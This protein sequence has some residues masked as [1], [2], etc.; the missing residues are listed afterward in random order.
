MSDYA[1]TL[2]WRRGLPSIDHRPRTESDKLVVVERSY[3]EIPVQSVASVEAMLLAG[4][5][6]QQLS[7]ALLGVGLHEV[8][9][10][11]AEKFCRCPATPG[12]SQAWRSAQTGHVW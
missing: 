12:L 4:P 8:N 10:Q 3:E 7:Q 5:S 11:A 1:G 2:R 9:R 6:D